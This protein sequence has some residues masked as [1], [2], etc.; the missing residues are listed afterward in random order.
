MYVNAGF[1]LVVAGAYALT[2]FEPLLLLV[3]LQAFAIVQQSLPFLRLGG[4]Y[5][6]SHLTRVPGMLSRIRPVLASLAPWRA[7]DDRVTELKPW[8]RVVVTAY[9]LVVVPVI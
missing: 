8:V 2:G 4:Y 7:P 6:V 1:A 9:V 3:V 5:I